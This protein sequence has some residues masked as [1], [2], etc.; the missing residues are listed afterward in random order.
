M[1][2][3]SSSV[4]NIFTT[5]ATLSIRTSSRR[6]FVSPYLAPLNLCCAFLSFI[7][8][9]AQRDVRHP[10]VATF[11]I[12]SS[13]SLTNHI[14]GSFPHLVISIPDIEN[15]IQDEL[16]RSPSPT[17]RR[18]GVPLPT[19]TRSGMT[20]PHL[21]Q[22]ARRQVQIFD[23]QPLPSPT[24]S[25]G[26][27]GHSNLSLHAF[28]SG[29]T[30][31]SASYGSPTQLASSA[32]NSLTDTASHIPRVPSSLSTSVPVHSLMSIRNAEAESKRKTVPTALHPPQFKV[33][34]ES[35]PSTSSSS[36]SIVSI[37]VSTNGGSNIST[38]P[39]SLSQSLALSGL[40]ITRTCANLQS[41]PVA[42]TLPFG[43]KGKA[44]AGLEIELGKALSSSCVNGD[45]HLKTKSLIPR[46]LNESLSI[47]TGDD[48]GLEHSR[49]HS[50]TS[51]SGFWK[52]LGAA[53]PAPAVVVSAVVGAA[54]ADG[55][56][57]QLSN[58]SVQTFE[59]G[60]TS[61]F[62]E[63]SENS[64]ATATETHPSPHRGAAA[65]SKPTSIVN[66]V[67]RIIT[68]NLFHD[69]STRHAFKTSGPSLLTQ[70]AP[71]RHSQVTCSSTIQPSPLRSARKR[72]PSSLAV[73]VDKQRSTSCKCTDPEH[74]HRSMMDE[75]RNKSW[76][77]CD[78][79]DLKSSPPAGMAT[80]A[81]P[82]PA[83]PCP[84]TP[85]PTPCEDRLLD[86]RKANAASSDA[87][88][89]EE[90]KLDTSDRESN[91]PNFTTNHLPAISIKIADLGNAT[92]ST[93]HYTED[94]QTRQ[95]RAPEAILGRSDWDARADI[96][97]VACLVSLP[98]DVLIFKLEPTW[99]RSLNY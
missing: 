4:W 84:N 90:P 69:P 86:S 88:A 94:I 50:G 60:S 30:A 10:S 99:N 27:S 32:G 23:S 2:S 95:Y 53:A 79:K 82:T 43:S 57:L 38:P 44:R 59:D 77:Q 48:Q 39:T 70:T 96:W 81:T 3:K 46:S 33:P 74:K 64:S 37:A 45:V 20:I 15:H 5:N 63:T 58:T 67:H 71:S 72:Q 54:G 26:R 11:G 7:T 35:S 8:N 61:N 89:H 52:D 14:D 42:S 92:P 40:S 75:C 62:N 28:S 9:F 66:G 83:L 85:P 36:S 16:F 17:S 91:L 19:K 73:Q 41:S 31:G 25:V 97:S 68:S 34:T 87:V 78:G 55:D 29:V 18:V 51:I 49:S 21:Q 24:R 93:K 1:P 80:S 22:R 6:T 12:Y 56:C 65:K 98:D 47:P 76:T 13:L